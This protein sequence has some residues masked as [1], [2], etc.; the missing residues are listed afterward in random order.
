MNLGEF[1]KFAKD[2]EINLPNIGVS[3]VFKLTAL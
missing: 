1:I 2:F 3:S